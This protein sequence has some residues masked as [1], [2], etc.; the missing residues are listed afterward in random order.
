MP[1]PDRRTVLAM[2]A[3][4]GTGPAN[5]RAGGSAIVVGAGIAGLAA[6]RRLADAGW[7]VTIIEA[8]DRV[9]GRIW[10]DRSLGQPVERGAG[11]L[12]GTMGNPLM[13][14]ARMAGVGLRSM[15]QE[16]PVFAADGKPVRSRDVERA[17]SRLENIVETID[18][19]D[20]EDIAL[21]D[22]IRRIDPT[23]WNDPLFRWALSANV[24]FEVGGPADA[25]SASEFDEDDAFGGDNVAIVEGYDRLLAPL[26]AGIDVR[27][28]VAAANIAPADAGG[29]TVE[30]SAETLSADRLVLAVPLG[31]LKAGAIGLPPLP[32]AIERAIGR[33]EAGAVS[34][35]ALA[36]DR[37]F[38]GKSPHIG[39]IDSREPGRFPFFTSRTTVTGANVLVG[40]ALGAYASR[41]AG[42]PDAFL[43]D[44]AAAILK[45]IHGAKMPAPGAALVTRWS[46]DPWTR[47]AYSFTGVHADSDDFNA[48]TQ[49][50]AGRIAFAGEHTSAR[51][52]GTVHGAYLSGLRAAD[53]VLGTL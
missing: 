36:F 39:Y 3:A 1:A 26:T 38:W 28:G 45:A 13:E 6:A 49:T 15:D 21:A 46:A 34:T 43:A 48:F 19:D 11:W 22:A 51:Y 40:Y 31:V 27:L 2:L 53:M 24:E 16:F 14:L 25:M 4:L 17:E 18:E 50:L 23:G 5:S 29:V 8:R 37:P 52:R 32:A 30:T 7:T 42:M 10:T 44:E 35:V 33:L 47:G 12:H 9:G 20:P 41:T